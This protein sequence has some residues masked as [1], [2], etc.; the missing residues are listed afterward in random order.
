MAAEIEKSSLDNSYETKIR[1]EHE[2]SENEKKLKPVVKKENVVSSKET[3]GSKVKK[4]FISE[5]AKDIGSYIL[6]DVLVPGIKDTIVSVVERAL[7]G[8][9]SGRRSYRDDSRDRVSYSSYYRSSGSSRN[10]RDERDR[11]DDYDRRGKVDYRNIVLRYREDAEKVVRVLRDSIREY[12]SA[13]V[14]ALL[15]L[16]DENS[17]WTDNDYGWTDERDISVRHVRNG[18]L[19]DVPEARYL[20]D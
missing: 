8:S 19:I 12:D 11:R 16:V 7:F 18:Y 1:K 5:D 14:A 13:T 15:D 9:S 20:G 2:A 6:F 4:S 17:S 3:L 10:R